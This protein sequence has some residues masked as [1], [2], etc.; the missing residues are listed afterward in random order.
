MNSYPEFIAGLPGGR[1]NIEMLIY[2]Y[3]DPHDQDKTA[4]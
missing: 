4:L 2:Q 1:L 3:R